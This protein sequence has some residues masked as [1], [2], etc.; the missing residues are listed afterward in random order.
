MRVFLTFPKG[1]DQ[2][3]PGWQEQLGYTGASSVHV[4][5]VTHAV[6]KLAGRKR[7][8]RSCRALGRANRYVDLSLLEE[9]L[10]KDGQHVL[11]AFP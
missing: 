2:Y 1:A 6:S 9:V 7:V 10:V 3:Y 5:V 11:V 4:A 8:A